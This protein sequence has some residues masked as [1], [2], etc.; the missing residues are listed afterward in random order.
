MDG[1]TII[2]TGATSGIGEATARL[3]AQQGACVAVVGRRADRGQA[4]VADILGAGGEAF[5]IQAD[6]NVDADIKAMVGAIMDKWGRLDFAFNN[7]GMFGPEAPFHEYDDEIWDQWM[8]LNLTG[9]YRCMKY[10]IAAMLESI[11]ATGVGAAIVNNASIMGHRG[12]PYAGPAYAATKHGVIGL[13]RQGAIAYVDQNIRV[14]AVSPGPTKTEITAATQS[15]PAET[16][17]KVIDDLLPIGRMGEAE[18]VAAAVLFL[19]SDGAGMITG[20][21]IP[22]DGGQLAKL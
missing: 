18:E 12:S 15:L 7:A 3:F 5:Y 17:Q 16:Q 14:N 22:V 10:E 9:V 1:K 4:V 2:V 8:N 19:C 11:N 6:M 21:D 13:T 20:H